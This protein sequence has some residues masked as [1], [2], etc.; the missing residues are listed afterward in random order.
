MGG[1]ECA[2]LVDPMEMLKR[3]PSNGEAIICCSTPADLVENDKG[4]L[5]SLVQ[6]R[7][8][9]N[10]FHHECGAATR[11]VISSTHPAEQ[12]VHSAEAGFR[13]RY[14]TAHLGEDDDQ[15]VL[16]KI[17]GLASHV[18]TG[19]QTQALALA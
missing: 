17:G 14:E 13:C 9:F 2:A 7:C 19:E 16:A 4:V 12:P 3:G 15:S 1:K 18:G 10:H 11:Q 8:G 6:D 5:G